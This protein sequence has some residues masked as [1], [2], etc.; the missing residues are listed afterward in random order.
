MRFSTCCILH[1]VW[2]ILLVSL[3]YFVGVWGGGR[4]GRGKLNLFCNTLLSKSHVTWFAQTPT[5]CI[6]KTLQCKTIL[7][8]MRN[9]IKQYQKLFVS[10]LGLSCFTLAFLTFCKWYLVFPRMCFKIY[11]QS[12]YLLYVPRY[13]VI[14][15]LTVN[16]WCFTTLPNSL[17]FFIPAAS[18][19]LINLFFWLRLHAQT[20]SDV[21]LAHSCLPFT[22]RS[23]HLHRSLY[24][25]LS[26]CNSDG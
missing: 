11:A 25:I 21:W 2:Y 24:K 18:F 19:S 1:M 4:E 23:H 14:S 7:K 26:T 20:L 6:D 15:Y 10:S 16:S 13:S 3:F 8:L 9:T 17:S 5:D 12:A 22:H